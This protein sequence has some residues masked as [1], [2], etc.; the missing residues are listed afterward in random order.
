M[1]INPHASHGAVRET[2]PSPRPEDGT[3]RGRANS[4]ECL[5][6]DCPKVSVIIPIHNVESYL[7]RCLDSV[8]GQTLHDIEILCVNDNSPDNSLSII[9]E[10]QRN[11]D[12]IKLINFGENKGVSFARNYAIDRAN[13]D[14][15][16]FVDPDDEI[17]PHF[18]E[19]LYARAISGGYEIVK[20]RALHIFEDGR[21]AFGINNENI[22]KNKLHFCRE[23]W[24]AIY[25][26]EFIIKNEINFTIGAMFG[27][28]I[29]FVCKAVSVVEHIAT[30]DDA[31]YAYHRRSDSSDGE[32]L[33]KN[34]LMSLFLSQNDIVKFINKRE[35]GPSS[36]DALFFYAFTNC[37]N[38]LRRTKS[39]DRMSIILYARLLTSM[40]ETCKRKPAFGYKLYESLPGLYELLSKNVPEEIEQY[41]FDFIKK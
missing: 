38:G 30:V 5:L 16:G 18:F 27:E 25:R 19:K 36:Y 9:S 14:Y 1:P 28:D 2:A 32:I 41:L 33:S 15:L 22:C 40:F 20:G 21:K 6:G 7:R 12:R 31:I 34:H 8:C 26:R 11:D 23:F 37:V 39:N 24:S 4:H 10:Y 3:L 17:G 29:A 13:G 35:V